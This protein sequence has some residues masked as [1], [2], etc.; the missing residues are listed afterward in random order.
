[1]Y[2]L[3]QP[4]YSGSLE[5][6]MSWLTQPFQVYFVSFH[7][8][9]YSLLIWGIFYI[10]PVVVWFLTAGCRVFSR[11]ASFNKAAHWKMSLSWSYRQESSEIWFRPQASEELSTSIGRPVARSSG[12]DVTISPF[13]TRQSNWELLEQTV[14]CWTFLSVW[15]G[16]SVPSYS[17]V[18]Q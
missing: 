15:Y 14:N 8:E 9:M 3:T 1:M 17:T 6:K 7:V 16:W 11:S 18:H 5:S 10:V 12:T 2:S 4:G 13:F